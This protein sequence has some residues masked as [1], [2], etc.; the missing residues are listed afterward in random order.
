MGELS[1]VI[2]PAIRPTVCEGRTAL[3]DPLWLNH[4]RHPVE[5][6]ESVADRVPTTGPG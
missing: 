4:N 6:V 1:V 2:Q 5:V 3:R